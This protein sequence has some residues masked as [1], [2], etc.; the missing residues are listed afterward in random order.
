[1]DRI[2]TTNDGVLGSNR[3]RGANPMVG[4]P[5]GRFDDRRVSNAPD[6]PRAYLGQG[7]ETGSDVASIGEHG[8]IRSRTV[9]AVPHLSGASV[10]GDVQERR[11]TPPDPAPSWA[12][13]SVWRMFVRWCEERSVQH[14]PASAE[15]IAEYLKHRAKRCGAPTLYKH[16][17]ALRQRTVGPNSTT[18]LQRELSRRRWTNW[19]QPRAGG[20]ARASLSVGGLSMRPRS[21]RSGRPRLNR[22]CEAQVLR[23][24]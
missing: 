18:R 20:V 10:A 2:P 6:A 24:A 12:Y 5:H 16:I 22:G 7:H 1:M 11:K 3:D 21:K 4:M 9:I 19:S 8:G 23:T 13:R 15:T 14:W 17:T